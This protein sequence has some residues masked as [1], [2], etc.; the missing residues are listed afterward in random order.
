MCLVESSFESHNNARVT[1]R[2]RNQNANKTTGDVVKP[3]KSQLLQ[4]HSEGKSSLPNFNTSGK[5][6]RKSKLLFN[7]SNNWNKPLSP[8]N[9]TTMK[10]LSA[11][12][13]NK[14]V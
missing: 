5:P 6:I 12:A 10:P 13:R 2:I 9:P 11:I 4:D 3:S 14:Y 1:S 8:S 7:F